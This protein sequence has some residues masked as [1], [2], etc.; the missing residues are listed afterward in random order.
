M[1]KLNIL[2]QYIYKFSV[3]EDLIASSLKVVSDLQYHPTTGQSVFTN[4]ELTSFIERSLE[5]VRVSEGIAFEHLKP[6]LMWANM[7]V[8]GDWHNRHYHANSLVS[9][10]IYL[11]TSDCRT[12]FSAPNFWHPT[13]K[14]GL[15]P[16]KAT[17][18]II[19][20]EPS[21][22]GTMIVFPSHLH[23]SV[24]NNASDET[25]YTISF[26]AFPCGQYLAP[27]EELTGIHLTLP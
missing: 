21:V 13:E 26:N 5:E 12:W 6:H 1:E 9:G 4:T 27:Q 3:P 20:K 15:A 23:H 17:E 25:R 11:N 24:D 2:P 10:I 8:R 19:H 22:A 16:Y 14:Y 7:R 18:E